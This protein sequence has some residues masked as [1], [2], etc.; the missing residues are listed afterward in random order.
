[1][2]DSKFAIYLLRANATPVNSIS[3]C[4]SEQVMF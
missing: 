2:L 1:M 3:G 4:T